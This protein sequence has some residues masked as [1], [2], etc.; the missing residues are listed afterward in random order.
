MD[1]QNANSTPSSSIELSSCSITEP[2]VSRSIELTLEIIGIC[3]IIAVLPTLAM[4]LCVLIAIARTN[5]LRTK[6]NAILCCILVINILQG[7]VSLPL[8][9]VLIIRIANNE[10]DCLARE[11]ARF[12]GSSFTIISMISVDL[13]TYERYT[14]ISNP[15]KYEERFTNKRIKAAVASIWIVSFSMMSTL[16]IDGAK[17]VGIAFATLVTV[18]T[19]VFNVTAHIII[20]RTVVRLRSQQ[21][22][23]QPNVA[24]AN[25]EATREQQR[26]ERRTIKFS[27]YIIVFLLACYMP[28]VFS[29][30]FNGLNIQATIFLAVAITFLMLHA[31]FS[32]LLY[33]WQSPQIGRAV[34]RLLRCGASVQISPAQ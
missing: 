28:S 7:C 10:T 26:K 30:I 22:A 4:N 2:I 11:A 34:K 25:S 12:L 24:D 32:P 14:A 8:F 33:I 23:I 20:H 9:G 19:Y 29:N 17:L 21:N 6:T 1:Q 18:T 27:V 3:N 15:F 31:T 5:T 16:I 13:L